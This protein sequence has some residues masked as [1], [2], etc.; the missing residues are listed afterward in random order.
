MNTCIRS[1]LISQRG[2]LIVITFYSERGQR[3]RVLSE[4]TMD[5]RDA[6]GIIEDLRTVLGEDST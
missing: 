3:G 5:K 1:Y 4:M 6:Y 2:D